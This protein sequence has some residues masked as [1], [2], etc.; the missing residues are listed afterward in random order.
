MYDYE[1]VGKLADEIDL[2][3]YASQSMKFV[4]RGHDSYATNCPLHIDKT[5]SLFITPS[6]NRFYCQSCKRGGSILQWLM[7][8]EGLSFAD[9]VDKMQTLAGHSIKSFESS[10]IMKV[11][12]SFKG[13]PK[14]EKEIIRP[15][16]SHDEYVRRFEDTCPQEWL[17]EG[18]SPE[19]MGKYEIRVDK[20][21]NRIV[22]PVY[23]KHFNLIGVKGRTRFPNYKEMHL[24]KYM[25]YNKI[26]TTDYFCGMKQAL[27]YVKSSLQIIIVE[28]LK[29][30]MKLDGWGYHNVVSAETSDLNNSQV[31]ILLELGIKEIV[32]AFDNDVNIDKLKHTARKINIYTNVFAVVDKRGLLS[33]KASPCDSGREVWEQLFAERIRM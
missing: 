1:E 14:D 3:N 30:V 24:S 29:S 15:V 6:K 31:I 2:F 33:E 5:P 22:Y 20:I 25:N 4:R 10:E 13:K 11:A 19:V 17:D 26:Y 18:I 12:M 28:G 16:L 9:S 7:D 21:A 32:L 27:D 23:D 8:F